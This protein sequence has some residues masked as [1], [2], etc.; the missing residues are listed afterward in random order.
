VR[1]PLRHVV[2]SRSE[3]PARRRAVRGA[4]S[5]GMTEPGAGPGESV[6][7]PRCWCA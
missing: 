3:P 1:T 7:V 4:W 6:R 5:G 2:S